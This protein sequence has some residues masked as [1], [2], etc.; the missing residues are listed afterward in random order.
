[1]ITDRYPKRIICL[2]EETTETL[3]L[4]GE[5]DRIVGISGFTVRPPQARKEKPKV[6]TFIDAKTEEILDLKP[7]LVIGFSD[8]QANI[9]K[10]LIEKGV[11]VWVNNYRSVEGVFDM[12]FQLGSLVGK[13]QE[14]LALIEKYKADILKIQQVTEQWTT[15]PK[16]YFEEWYDPLITGI[17]WVGDLI[18]M[19]GG[20]NIFPEMSKS[21]LAK[22]RIL[23]N[24]QEVIARNPDII[25]ASWCGKMFKKDKMLARS[26]W[27]QI[28]AV[29]HDDIYEIDSSIILQ[30]GP[31]AVGEGLILL[32]DIFKRWVEKR[33]NI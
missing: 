27:E 10:E 28:E 8:I 6:S 2:T 21:S 20:E 7:D 19:A 18:E 13:Q 16:V 3:Y 5:Q 4:L 25:L 15:K 31:A 29:K 23:E 17:E 24:D 32:H 12:I 11:T 9:A 22:G 30:P 14:A 1:M 33:S 26:G